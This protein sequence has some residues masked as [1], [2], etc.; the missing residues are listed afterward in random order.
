[1]ALCAQRIKLQ[2]KLL[3]G[4]NGNNDADVMEAHLYLYV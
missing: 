4:S 1:M 3:I 2:K